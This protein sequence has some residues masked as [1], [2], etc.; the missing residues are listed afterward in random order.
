MRPL[1]QRVHLGGLSCIDATCCIDT[2]ENRFGADKSGF[3]RVLLAESKHKRQSLI[4]G[5]LTRY[6]LG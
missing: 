2:S 1:L 4:R 5:K 3:R 6:R